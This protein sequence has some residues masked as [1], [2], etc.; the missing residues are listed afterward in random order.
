MKYTQKY[1]SIEGIHCAGCV[2]RIDQ[3]LSNKQGIQEATTDLCSATLFVSYSEEEISLD[4]IIIQI[5]QLGFKASVLQE[6]AYNKEQDEKQKQEAKHLQR[7]AF[8]GIFVSL[9]MMLAGYILPP[10]IHHISMIVGVVF[11]YLFL[12]F[13]FHK[14]AIKQIIRGSI[15]MDTLISLSTTIAFITTCYLS[16]FHQT[17]TDTIHIYMD[18][19]VMIISFVL[20]GK[21][22]EKR[23]LLQ[24]SSAISNW[25][26]I[27][28]LEARVLRD[29]KVV[30]LPIEK[31]MQ[32]D[33][34]R[35]NKGDMIPVDGY[36]A[37]GTTTI[38]EQMLTGEAMP[39]TKKEKDNVYCGSINLSQ[40]ID[41]R[42]R[43][44]GKQTLLGKI[45]ESV[46]KAQT[47]KP[48]IRRVADRIASVFVPAILALALSTFVVWYFILSSSLL[49]ALSYAVSV[50]VIACPCALGL[51]T[52]TALTIALG[53]MARQG[54]LVRNAEAIEL[55][56]KI[57]KVL[58]DKTGTITYGK[59]EV[60][61]IRWQNNSIN[62]EYALSLLAKAE[63]HSS[64]PLARSIVKYTDP[65]NL[66][67]VGEIEVKEI[68]GM[69]IEFTHQEDRYRVGN[70]QFSTYSE[71]TISSKNAI[72]Y[73][74]N[75][76]LIAT[77]YFY[78]TPLPE[79]KEELSW[80]MQQGYAPEILTGDNPQE[81]ERVSKALGLILYQAD[82]LPQDKEAILRRY[83][84]SKIST[85]FLGDGVNDASAFTQANV[86]VAMASGSDLSRS[87]A[88]VVFSI[89]DLSLLRKSIIMSRTTMQSIYSNFA[90]AFGYNL[91]A[92]PWA[93]GLGTLWGIPSI[94]PAW[95]AGAM[96]LSS[97]SVILNSMYLRIRL[98]RAIQKIYK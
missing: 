48:R 81:A 64:H 8:I 59:P 18:A 56:P 93:M 72:Y 44:V 58:L 16:F 4:E 95:S 89:P 28:P 90:W 22:I 42:V 6:E 35:V 25:V 71:E 84:D 60:Q 88:D 2:A 7:D 10:N 87:I 57:Q 26:K 13:R 33:I 51:A 43:E 69:G 79:A 52:P 41:V 85:L 68:V 19:V 82:L 9:F 12:G 77:I 38:E 37:K 39:V 3:T 27:Q 86:S 76:H 14:T 92:I 29:D 45:I 30:R 96:A 75:D 34:V 24:T 65:Q 1:L 62:K 54:I 91:F 53:Y 40:S 67:D 73:T 17:K 50:L 23:A 20:L 47:T 15:S 66:Q 78:D 63:R 94:S 74:Q 32:G 61:E 36:I 46:R 21:W 11:V 98:Q 83:Q 80:C 5:K 55:L 70:A 49:E 31:V 97:L